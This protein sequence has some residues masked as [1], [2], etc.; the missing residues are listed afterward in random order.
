MILS[1][2]YPELKADEQF[3]NLISNLIKIED[4][5]MNARKYYNAIV[6]IYNNKIEIFPNCLIAKL[7][8]FF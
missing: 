1:E 2:N 8:L 7:W 5:L 3:R 4:E 6:R